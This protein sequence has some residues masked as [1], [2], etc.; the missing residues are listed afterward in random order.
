MLKPVQFP[1]MSA[2]GNVLRRL[3][4]FRHP[5]ADVWV[6]QARNGTSA[7]GWLPQNSRKR[8][9]DTTHIATLRD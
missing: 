6:N 1:T 4:K 9:S 7:N 8:L 3:L 2:D 5:A